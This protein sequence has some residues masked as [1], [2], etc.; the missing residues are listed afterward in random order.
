MHAAPRGEDA[1][2]TL[3][4][5]PYDE[6]NVNFD[7]IVRTRLGQPYGHNKVFRH[8]ARRDFNYEKCKGC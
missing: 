7:N 8:G 3:I 1:A 2:K 4:V 5:A 6:L